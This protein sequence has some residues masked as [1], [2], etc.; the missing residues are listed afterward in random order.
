MCWIPSRDQYVRGIATG[1]R[2]FMK[3]HHTAEGKGQSRGGGGYTAE[4][5]P[6]K[7]GES[8][9]KRIGVLETNALLSH[10][11]VS[12]LQ[13]IK[14]IRGQKNDDY[15][16]QFMAGYNP[17]VTKVPFVYRKFVNQLKASGVNVVKS[18]T[19]TNIMAMTDKDVDELAGDR[20]L[21]D[22][23]GVDWE[24]GLKELRGGLFD[25]AM[26]GGHGGERWSAIKLTEPLPNPVMEEPLRHMLRLTGKQF[27]GVLSGEHSIGSFGTGPTAMKK[28]LEAIDLPKEIEKTRAIISGGRKSE[29]D[30]AIRRLGYLKSAHKL[31]LHPADYMLKRVPVLPPSFRPVSLM[32]NDMPLV[33]DANVLYKELMEANKN[34]GLLQNEVGSDG[35]G[36][37]RLVVYDAFKA[38]TGLGDPITQKSQDRNVKGLLRSV[39]GTSPKYGTVQRKLISTTVDNVGRAVITPNPDLD[40][41]TVGLPE[42]KAYNAY[43]KFV[44]RRLVRQGMA[45]SQALEAIKERKP[46]AQKAL[47]EEME[48][49]PVYIS[50]APVLHKFGIMAFRPVLTK[51]DTLQVSPLIVKGFGADFDGDTMNYHVPSSDDAREEALTRMLPSKNIFSVA[52]MR[53]VV[54]APANEYVGGIYHATSAKNEDRPK[55][56]F[57]TVADMRKAYARGDVLAGDR[58][59]ILEKK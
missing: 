49:R 6:A 1:S 47:L 43:E 2:F 57:Q 42:D 25:K 13:D 50:R 34:W 46:V 35:V 11:A 54:H 27:R 40:M 48:T 23:G 29:R 59:Q 39:F 41:D 24:K 5:T 20:E 44:T 12:T 7:G 3:L 19:Q 55:K 16:M 33:S 45:M 36:N 30:S 14:N 58:V 18:G 28:A 26:T 4:E 53:S 37:D 15:W 17:T 52:D 10:G 22:S 32:S 9:S 38:V 31:G 8:G 56:I 21:V 51:S